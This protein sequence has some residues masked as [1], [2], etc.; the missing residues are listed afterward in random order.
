MIQKSTVASHEELAPHLKAFRFDILSGYFAS[1]SVK[2]FTRGSNSLTK[3]AYQSTD[4][5]RQSSKNLGGRSSK[6][7]NEYN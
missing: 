1:D 6:L 2:Q 5:V 4:F 3:Q 7:G